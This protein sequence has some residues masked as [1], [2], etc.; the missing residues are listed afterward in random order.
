[1]KKKV[2]SLV[3]LAAVTVSTL[4]G[5]GGSKYEPELPT[6]PEEAE[7]FV[8][9]IEDLPEDFIKGMDVSSVLA[10]EAS[11]VVYYNEDGEEEDLFK[12][13]AD[14]GVNYI[15]VRVWNNPY[16][17][18]GNGYGGGN[19]DVEKAAEIGKRAAKY[20]M[21][22]LVDFHY[23]D[24]WAD[25]SKQF[26]PVAWSGKSVEE[27][28]EL[29]YDFT[30]ESLNTI[31]KEGADVGMVQVGNEINNGMAGEYKSDDVLALVQS[32]CEAV[33]AVADDK[34]MDIKIAV[35]YTEIENFDY[36]L[37]LAGRLEDA[38]VD[39]DVFGVSYYPFWH[40]TM[41]N[42]TNVLQSVRDTYGKETCVLETSYAYTEEDGDGSANSI[43]EGNMVDGYPA[44][45]QGQATCVRDV[46]AAA[47]DGGAIGVFYWE[48]AWIPVG[49]DLESNQ[50]LWEKNGSG[51]ASSYAAAYDP[52]DAGKYYGGSSWDNQAFFDFTGHK[53]ASLDV[54]KYLNYGATCGLEVVSVKE[55]KVEVAIGSPVEMPENVEVVYNDS[56]V[57]DGSISVTWDE[58]QVAAVDTSTAGEYT[59]E[60]TAEDGTKVTAT[61]KVNNI[62]QLQNAGFEDDDVSMWKVSFEGS[63]NPTD[64]Q[65][66]ESDAV[67]GT[68]AFHFYS[69]SEQEFTVEQ[70]VSGLTAG[71]YTATAN[72]QGGDV[73]DAAEIVLYVIV[74]DT[75]YESDPVTLAGWVNWQSPKITDIPVEGESEVTVGMS[76]K[77]AA[78]GWGTMDD[79]ELYCQ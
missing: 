53:L 27:K 29:L 22:L 33:R 12:I 6:G 55:T 37:E 35:H 18:D 4:I 67:S 28:Q 61:V 48:G 16:D 51:W 5:C 40:G 73:G 30:V 59:V 64:V 57:T 54:F 49:D 43:G 7:I 75:R 60:G 42:L 36:T 62:N 24:F 63:A 41:E 13:L 2:L 76:V 65:D 25:P 50:E 45:V 78:K 8:E 9:P 19:N 46:C 77:C 72:I 66:K 56:T 34:D 1:M 15:R 10:E 70:T 26:V 11:G 31:I 38:G 74:G 17:E 47:S 20:G 39:Y 79:F 58:A 23:S 52:Q 32:G 71:D 69:E 44:S 21:K 3:L 68:K 14:S